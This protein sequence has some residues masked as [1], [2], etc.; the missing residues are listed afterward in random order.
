[1]F[2]GEE[3]LLIGLYR[4]HLPTTISDGSFKRIFG[5]GHT[6]VSMVFNAF[7][8]FL[9][10][11]WGYLLFDNLQ[12]WLPYLPDCAQA[13]RDKCN[14]K[15]CYFPNSRS[16]GGLRVAGFIDNTMNATCRPGGGPA[17]DGQNAPRNDSLIQ[18]AWYN[19][20]KKMH[21]MKYQT[22]DLPNGMNM[23]VWGPIS[24]RHNDLTSLRDSHINDLLV[25]L[26]HD[27]DYQWVIYG[28]SAYVHVPDPTF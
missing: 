19:G 12:F 1:M 8:E 9:V 17:R 11:N 3:F 10:N 2:H 6:A 20:W 28:D 15:G 27:R 7:I 21:G 24:V 16:P 25:D 13:V 18:R 14:E 5:L 22:V 26:Q 23:H 4:L